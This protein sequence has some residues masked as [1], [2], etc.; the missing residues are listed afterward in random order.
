[1]EFKISESRLNGKVPI[2]C[3]NDEGEILW[4]R[5]YDYVNDNTA[6]Y[7]QIAE[8]KRVKLTNL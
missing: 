6:L 8:G 1:M 3:V 2:T 5:K 4:V 7:K